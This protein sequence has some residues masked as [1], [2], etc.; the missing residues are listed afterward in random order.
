MSYDRT[1]ARPTGSDRPKDETV[2]TSSLRR[3]GFHPRGRAT[4]RLRALSVRRAVEAGPHGIRMPLRTR[5]LMRDRDVD[6][7]IR[8]GVTLLVTE[9]GLPYWAERCGNR[10][11]PLHARVRASFAIGR[12]HLPVAKYSAPA[13]RPCRP[14]RSRR[15]VRRRRS[16]RAG[17]RSGGESD[18][19]GDGP[20]ADV[21][22]HEA[23][24]LM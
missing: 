14:Q 5:E 11:R 16:S 19:G 21:A 8:N 13:R 10:T 4:A 6:R 23:W 18:P 12:R 3:L 17:P 7:Y 15:R 1:H 24:R 2:V 20:G 9:D 22:A